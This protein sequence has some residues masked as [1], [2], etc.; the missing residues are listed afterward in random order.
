MKPKYRYFKEHYKGMNDELCIC[1]DRYIYD[2]ENY[3]LPD[4]TS[5]KLN[6]VI[7]VSNDSST[8]ISYKET[9]V[10]EY[11]LYRL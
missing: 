4:H 11:F 10:E 9:T 1:I 5:I 2:G 6:K 8:S 7:K 3:V